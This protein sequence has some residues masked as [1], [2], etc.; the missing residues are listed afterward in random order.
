[1]KIVHGITIWLL[2]GIVG[3]LC[4]IA[5]ANR[6]CGFWPPAMGIG[7]MVLTGPGSG[8]TMWIIPESSF[9]CDWVRPAERR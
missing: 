1:M 3:A 4:Y 5:D 9:H 6:Q 7:W 8:L 2:L